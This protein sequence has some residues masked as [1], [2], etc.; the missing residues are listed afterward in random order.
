MARIAGVPAATAQGWLN[1]RHFPVPALRPNYLRMVERL[2]LT[3]QV[4]ADLWDESWTSLQPRLRTEHVPYLGLRPFEAADHNLYFGR[5]RE[6]ARLAKVVLDRFTSGHGMVVVVGPSGIG[7]SSLLAAGLVGKEAT[8]GALAGRSIVQVAVG[9]LADGSLP[10]AEIVVVDQLEEAFTF[11]DD[12]RTAVF[13]ALSEVAGR[14]VVVVALRAD[15]FADASQEPLL[16]PALARPFLVEPLSRDEVREVIV[17]P[18]RQVGAAVDDD[19]AEVVLDDLAVGST[20]RPAAVDVLPLLSNA[21]LVTWAASTGNRLTLADYVRSGGVAS[22][23]QA[24]AE[25]VFQ[26]LGVEQQASA[27]RLILRLVRVSDDLLVREPLPLDDIDDADRPGLDPFVSARMLTVAD[28][29]IRISHDALLTHWQRLQEWI[30]ES[31]ADLVVLQQ[32]RRTARVWHDSGCATEALIP[33]ARMEVFSKW[34][35]D[36]QR[37]RVLSPREKEFVTASRNHFASELARE[38]RVNVR[39][40]RGRNLA[41]ALTS[42]AVMLTLVTGLLYSQGRGLQAAANSAKLDAQSRQVAIEA[43]SIDRDVLRPRGPGPT[44]RGR[45]GW[46]GAARGE[47]TDE[48]LPAPSRDRLAGPGG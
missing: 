38:Q 24:L 30:D 3:D 7:K 25:E 9:H 48:G 33:V 39:L 37:E 23:V 11:D 13:A 43:Q 2:G 4:P 16:G 5:Q 14:R 18:A 12:T 32:L 35:S 22:A 6:T 42:L 26:S 29:S 36:P 28:D 1:G 34:L 44:A 27:Q 47:L 8:A 21:L 41:V 31:R 45:A 20:A 17:G 10:D 19:L 46:P 15:A 40:R